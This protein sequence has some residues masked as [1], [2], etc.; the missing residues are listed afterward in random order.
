M[1]QL[2]Y[3]L[4]ITIYSVIAIF[5]VVTF[6]MLYVGASFVDIKV[7][8]SIAMI[9]GITWWVACNIQQELTD[10]I[11]DLKKEIKELKEKENDENAY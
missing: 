4:K 1:K 2:V 10:E 7:L 8:C 6:C 11:K 9:I 5:S 3:L